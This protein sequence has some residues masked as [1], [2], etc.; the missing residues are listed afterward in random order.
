MPKTMNNL[1]NKWSK[2]NI[3]C[4]NRNDNFLLLFLQIEADSQPNIAK[5]QLRLSYEEY[6]TIANLVVHY[7][8]KNES[9]DMHKS[10]VK[11][12]I[13]CLDFF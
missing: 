1:L 4:F 6:R 10:Q 2:P 5:K 11:N 12:Y 3:S 7:L 9:D 13:Y 8:R